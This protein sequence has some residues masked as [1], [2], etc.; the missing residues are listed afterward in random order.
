MKCDVPEERSLGIRR[1]Q[2]Q[3]SRT[4]ECTLQIHL[5]CGPETNLCHCCAHVVWCYPADKVPP[6]KKLGMCLC[7]SQSSP[8]AAEAPNSQALVGAGLWRNATDG[9]LTAC[10]H[11]FSRY[12]RVSH[13]H[14]HCDFSGV[15]MWWIWWVHLCHPWRLQGRPKSFSWP[16]TDW[17]RRARGSRWQGQSRGSTHQWCGEK[18]TSNK[19]SGASWCAIHLFKVTSCLS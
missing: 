8:G 17:P 12:P 10:H 11:L 3:M 2:N 9:H 14:S 1:A 4:G 18:W 19:T 15:Q 6:L 7:G 13:H 16:L 5:P